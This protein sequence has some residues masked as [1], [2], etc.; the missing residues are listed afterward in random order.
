MTKTEAIATFGNQS[1]LA[2]AMRVTRG[3]VSQW[4]EELPLVIADRVRGA[5]LRLGRAI[6]GMDGR[7]RFSRSTILGDVLAADDLELEVADRMRGVALRLGLMPVQ[8]SP[9]PATAGEAV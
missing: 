4:P 1:E 2:R 9:S 7:T 5:A 3:Y 6:P 8:R